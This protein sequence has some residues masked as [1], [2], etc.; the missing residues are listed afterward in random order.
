MEVGLVCEGCR[1]QFDCLLV[2]EKLCEEGIRAERLDPVR[3]CVL[4]A[5][6][7]EIGGDD[8]W[9]PGGDGSRQD[10][11]ILGMVR[12]LFEEGLDLLGWHLGVRV[13]RGERAGYSLQSAIDGRRPFL[14]VGG[15]VALDQAPPGLVQDEGAPAQLEQTLQGVPDERVPK[16]PGVED[17]GV[18]DRGR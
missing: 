1:A 16:V 14:S 15:E 13:D 6:I 11:A 3:V 2:V 10:V 8:E 12:H 18:N 5:E 9:C 4:G 7:L 17:A